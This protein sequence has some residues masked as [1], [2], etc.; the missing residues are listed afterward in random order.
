[1]NMGKLVRV[2]AVGLG[3]VCRNRHLPAMKRSRR[4]EL[5][6][7]IDR[8]GSLSKSVAA[9]YG[10]RHDYAGTRLCD[11]PW[12]DE[13]D[14]I[15]IGTAP[16]AHYSIAREALNHG[17]HVLTEKPFAMTEEEGMELVAL[18]R[19]KGVVLGIVHNFQF[20]N[21]F[22]RLEADITSGKL[23]EIKSVIARQLGNP[24]RRLP[25]WYESLP[26]GLFYDESPHLLYL[27]RRLCGGEEPL[28]ARVDGMG[29]STGLV[30]PAV[31]EALYIGNIR[32]RS[33]PISLLMSFESP[34]SEWHL[35]V[36]GD[37][38]MGLVDLFRDIYIRLPND[39]GHDTYSVIRT[40]VTATLQHWAQHFT[41]GLSH[42]SGRLNYG[43]AEVFARFADAV[44][45]GGE[46]LDLSGEDA[47]AILSMQ[48][49][50]IASARWIAR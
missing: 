38:G 8:D 6:G 34:I 17:K 46:I 19:S 3:W 41:S 49:E 2:A 28:L 26:L 35:C 32:G 15:T 45:R 39:G 29:S 21:S 31:M 43:N 1:M 9:S 18:A 48:H 10:M 40:S 4:F 25:S 27:I 36:M 11:V 23:G 37:E 42:L 12:L 24:R 30:T 22:R 7:A 44:L 33:C 47:Q 5:V 50:L 16:H 14:A 13:I 20:A